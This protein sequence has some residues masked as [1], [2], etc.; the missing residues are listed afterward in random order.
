MRNSRRGA[1]AAT[2]LALALAIA[3]A[4]ETAPPVPDGRRLRDIVAE[5]YGDGGVLIG[6]T[7]GSWAFGSNQGLVLDREFSYVTPENDFKQSIVRGKPGSWN[8]SRAD[9]WLPHV[10]ENGQVL[11][12]HAP[13]SPQCSGWVKDDSRT[14]EELEKELRLF[15][16]ALVD[17][18]A[19][20]PGVAYLDVVNETVTGGGDW[21]GPRPGTNRWENPWLLIGQDDDPNQTPL[22]IR[23][24]F[25]IAQRA[26]P[27]VKLIY[28]QNTPPSSTAAWDRIKRTIA[29][30]RGRGLEV[31]GIG[32]QAHVSVGWE[33]EEEL[34]ALSE[35]I[36]WAHANDL[37]F[38]VTE[39]SVWIKN[40]CDKPEN[41]EAQA[42]TYAAI[43]DALL[44]KRSSGVVG[45]N[46][47]GVSDAHG[48]RASWCGYLFDGEY[49]PKP[50]YYAV[51]EVLERHADQTGPASWI[52][53]PLAL[54]GGG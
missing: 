7:T 8:W 3:V 32:W 21:F 5:G 38:H 4:D 30:L 9:A 13:I 49:R 53:L 52:A 34:Q 19:G 42:R 16:N 23:Y 47:W 24:A 15:M 14:P 25:E 20:Q 54:R 36:D 6:A 12:M 43:V 50:A 22:Y 11:R 27:E 10:Q 45:W 26:R 33:R 44:G 31:D 48:G 17:R 28:N 39:A 41:L 35:L 29:Y 2:L 51:Q 46:T 1:A 40:G 37:E 18:Y